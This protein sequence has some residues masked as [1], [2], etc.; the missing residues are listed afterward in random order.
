MEYFNNNRRIYGEVRVERGFN[1]VTQE[2]E[3]ERREE[4][5]GVICTTSLCP[6]VKSGGTR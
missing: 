5:D 6:S 2:R 4:T 3:K 1:E